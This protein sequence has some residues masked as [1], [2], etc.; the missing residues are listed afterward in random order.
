MR[1]FTKLGLGL[2]C[3][4]ILAA[5]AA[6]QQ[7]KPKANPEGKPEAKP[8]AKPEGQGGDD[9]AAMM[10]EMMKYAAPGEHHGHLKPLAGKW[11]LA[12]KF[13][14]SPEAPWDDSTGDATLEWILG[15]RFLQLKVKSPPSEAMPMEFEGFGLLGYDNYGKKYVSAWMDSMFTGI[16]MM[17]GSCDASAKTITL[18][19]E[20]DDPMTGGKSKQRWVY[21]IIN[22]DKFVF[23]MWGPGEDGK[24]FMNGEIT[25]NRVK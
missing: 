3:A 18:T 4:L 22:D 10:A 23:E 15:G 11:K 24:E 13:R 19:G 16:M 14:M 17:N 12:S 5:P 25:Y 7:E 6:A 20:N 8:E 1:R 9:M 2:W 21:K